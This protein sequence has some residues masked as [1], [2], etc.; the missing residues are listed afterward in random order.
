MSIFAQRRDGLRRLLAEKSL[1]ALLVSDEHNV[2][3]LTGFTGDSSYL[4]VTGQRELLL[5]DRRYTQQLDEECP[6]LALEVRAPGSTITGFAAEALSKMGFTSLG[7]EADSA[8]VAFCEK[9]QRSLKATTLA[10][11]SGLVESLREL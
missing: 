2:T 6:G 11:T 4:L 8:A 3:Y 5:T 1:A 10:S 7:I 9:L